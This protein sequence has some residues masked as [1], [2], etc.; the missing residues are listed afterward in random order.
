MPVRMTIL[1]SGSAGNCTYL[2]TDGMKILIDAGFSGRQITRRLA[3]IDRSPE[4]LDAILVT[5]EH[6]DHIQG[7]KTL[8]PRHDIPVFCNRMTREAIEPGLKKP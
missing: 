7:L 3:T 6:S 2:E 4:M 1:G 5:H 8:C